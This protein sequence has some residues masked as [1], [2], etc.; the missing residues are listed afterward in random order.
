[1]K[2]P[3]INR[4]VHKMAGGNGATPAAGGLLPVVN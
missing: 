4:F 1:M 3:K 2:K